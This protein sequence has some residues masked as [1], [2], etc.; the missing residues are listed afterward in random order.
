MSAVLES[1]CYRRFCYKNTHKSSSSLAV[2]LPHV[3]DK[4]HKFMSGNA[5]NSIVGNVCS[6]P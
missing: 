2:S 5:I 1:S 3:P 4:L 6:N